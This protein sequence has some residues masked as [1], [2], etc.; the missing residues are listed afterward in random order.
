MTWCVKHF[1]TFYWICH[2]QFDT[3]PCYFVSYYILPSGAAALSGS[4]THTISTSVIVFELTGQITHILPVMV[5]HLETHY[6]MNF[7]LD[8]MHQAK[9]NLLTLYIFILENISLC[10]L[11][12]FNTLFICRSIMLQFWHVFEFFAMKFCFRIIRLGI[13]C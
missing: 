8:M 13:C 3:P 1:L 2:H 6:L 11:Q 12:D 4:V 5:R 9:F 7:K 10:K